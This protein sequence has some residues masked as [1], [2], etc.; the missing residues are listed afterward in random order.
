LSFGLPATVRGLS[1]LGAV[2]RRDATRTPDGNVLAD[3]EGAVNDPA[4]LSAALD[5]VPGVIGHGLFP[6][7]LVT[8]VLVGRPNGA[9]ERLVR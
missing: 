1:K 2:R 5:A 7:E 4:E 8:Q 3:F 6:P 9:V